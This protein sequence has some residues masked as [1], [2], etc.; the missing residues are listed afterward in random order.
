VYASSFGHAWQDEPAPVN[1]RCAGFQTLLVRAV[2]W[3][4]KRPVDFPVPPD[5]PNE[6]ALSLRPPVGEPGADP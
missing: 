5:F 6:E 2:Q 4:A 1:F 3:L